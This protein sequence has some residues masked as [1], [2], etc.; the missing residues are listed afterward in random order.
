MDPVFAEALITNMPDAV[1]YS[2]RDGVVRYWNNGAERMFGHTAAEAIGRSLDLIIPEGLR[3]RH[4]TGYH[5]TMRTGQT[6]YGDGQTLSVPAVRK[7]GKRISVAFTIVPFVDDRGSMTGIAAI[8]RDVTAQF[9][10][11]RAL[12]REVAELRQRG[13]Q[14]S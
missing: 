13:Q 2:D 7:D 11:M 1:V 9:E 3:A 6:R 12:R 4:W 10:E 5:E 14:A 8:M